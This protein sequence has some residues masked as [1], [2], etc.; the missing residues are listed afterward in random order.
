MHKVE[1]GKFCS[2][3]SCIPL[4]KIPFGGR[5]KLLKEN[6]CC[7]DC[8]PNN[9]KLSRPRVCGCEKEGRGCG[10]THEIHKLFC[11]EAKLCFHSIS[12]TVIKAEESLKLSREEEEGA[13]LQ[14]MKIPT[15]RPDG[16]DLLFELVLWDT[17][18]TNHYVR[19][20]HAKKMDFQVGKK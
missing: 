7:G 9:L 17:G 15:L 19:I 11:R 20:G 2:S 4:K 1:E 13:T 6:K 3:H 5:I 12:S 16:R 10:K 8:P 18:S 14:I